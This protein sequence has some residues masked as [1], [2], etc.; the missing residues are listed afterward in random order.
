MIWGAS[1]WHPIN[2]DAPA[3]DIPLTT[4]EIP[5]NTTTILYSELTADARHSTMEPVVDD[6]R[7]WKIEVLIIFHQF[8][9]ARCPSLVSIIT[10]LHRSHNLLRKLGMPQNQI[11]TSSSVSYNLGSLLHKLQQEQAY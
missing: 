9:G 3:N 8:L 6:D 5:S 2:E 10:C 4:I 11:G 7:L 1:F